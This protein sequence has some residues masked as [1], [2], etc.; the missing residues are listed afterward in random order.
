M[1]FERAVPVDVGGVALISAATN[2][3]AG[4]ANT[5]FPGLE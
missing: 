5:D 2:G 3:N 4:G 1:Q